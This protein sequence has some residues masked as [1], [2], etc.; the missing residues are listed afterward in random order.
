MV[1]FD[2]LLSYFFKIL[3]FAGVALSISIVILWFI[4]IALPRQHNELMLSMLALSSVDR[5]FEPR[6]GKTKDYKIGI[7]CFSANYTTLRNK[8]KYWLTQNQEN[9]SERKNISICRIRIKS[10][11]GKI[12][13]S[14]DCCFSELFISTIK[15]QL[16]VLVYYKV[17][18][19]ITSSIETCSRHDIGEKLLIWC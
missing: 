6:S 13:L 1:L 8:N 15:I 11:R 16:S 10:L 12:C 9:K 17:D 19:V 4:S 14:A 18:I 2:I 3:C 5:G 7:C